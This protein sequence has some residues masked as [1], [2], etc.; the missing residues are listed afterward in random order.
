MNCKISIL[1]KD[2][3]G[4]FYPVFCQIMKTAFACYTQRIVNF[5][6]EKVYAPANF[7]FWINNQYKTIIVVKIKKE[8]AGFA[9]ID[10]PY[11]G[12]SMCRWL[13]IRSEYQ[14]QGLGSKMINAWV[15][16]ARSQGCHKIELAAQTA[17]KKFYEKVGLT[18]EGERQLSYFG[19]NQYIFGKIIGQPNEKTMI[20]YF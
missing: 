17:A 15:D 9:M 18:L 14:K 2:D 16:L 3:I 6:I 10:Q 8:F 19:T 20:K 13:G 11:G 7:F 5:F 1:T 4:T 12:V